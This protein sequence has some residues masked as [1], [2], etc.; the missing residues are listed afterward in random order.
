MVDVRRRGLRRVDREL[1]RVGLLVG[2]DARLTSISGLVAGEPVTGSWWSHELAHDIF[3]VYEALEERDDLLCIKLV[4]GKVTFVARELWPALFAV[5]TSGESWQTRGLS[6]PAR[7]L[8]GRVEREGPLRTDELPRRAARPRTGDLVRELE[9]CLLVY[10]DEFH[11][12]RGAHAKRLESWERWRKSVRLPKP[13]L[14]PETA[15]SRIESAV[16]QLGG[17]KPRVPWPT[18]KGP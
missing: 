3:W 1:A 5:A 11:T 12:E 17:A 9:R 14:R 13:R 7:T 10:S 8:L 4:A 16:R 15:R 2:H 6:G 18:Q